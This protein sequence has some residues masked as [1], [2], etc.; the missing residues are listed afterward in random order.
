[1]SLIDDIHFFNWIKFC[2]MTHFNKLNFALKSGAIYMVW[3]FI[4][5]IL[6]TFKIKSAV[7]NGPFLNFENERP[8]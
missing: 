6:L 7:S 1:M 2:K 3:Y 8:D 4:L 5:E